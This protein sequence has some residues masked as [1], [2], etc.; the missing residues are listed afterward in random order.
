[1]TRPHMLRIYNQTHLMIKD[2]SSAVHSVDKKTKSNTACYTKIINVLWCVSYILT[3]RSA[4]F[5][6]TQK[7]CFLHLEYI[8]KHNESAFFQLSEVGTKDGAATHRSPLQAP[9]ELVPF[10]GKERDEE[11]GYGYFGAR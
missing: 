8:Y 3:K 6:I 11:T 2:K 5:G 1:M 4:S 9:L 7:G 10:T